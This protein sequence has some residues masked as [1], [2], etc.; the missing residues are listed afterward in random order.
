MIRFYPCALP[1][2]GSSKMKH[3]LSVVRYKAPRIKLHRVELADDGGGKCFTLFISSRLFLSFRCLHKFYVRNM[4]GDSIKKYTE[5]LNHL[6][7]CFLS[8]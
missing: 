8:V 3:I 4:C 1:Y 6:G 2:F 7:L 5:E